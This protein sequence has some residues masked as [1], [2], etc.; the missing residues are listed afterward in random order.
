VKACRRLK[1]LVFLVLSMAWAELLPAQE[2]DAAEE[3][4]NVDMDALF[5]NAEDSEYSEPEIP[6]AR[7][8]ILSLFQP[9][10]GIYVDYSV[11]GSYLPG[12]GKNV[13]KAERA[14]YSPWGSKFHFDDLFAGNHDF[15]AEMKASFALDIRISSSLRFWQSIKFSLPSSFVPTFDEFYCDYNLS[16]RAFIKIGRYDYRW[17]LS[18]NFPYTNLLIR[19]P[20]N[21]KTDPG[22]LYLLKIDVP[23]GIGGFQFI[24]Y[25]REQYFDKTAPKLNQFAF[26]GKFNLATRFVDVDFGTL[27]PPR[28]FYNSEGTDIMPWRSFLSA[29]STVFRATEIYAEVLLAVFKD[30]KEGT[31][32]SAS[33]GFYQDFFNDKL[34]INGEF[35]YNAEFESG[36]YQEANPFQSEKKEFLFMPGTNLALNAVFKPGGVGNPKIALQTFYNTREHSGKITPGMSITP[37]EHFSFYFAV[38]FVFGD[39]DGG[40]YRTTDMPFSFVFMATINGSFRFTHY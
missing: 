31:H 29:K 21:Y 16:N 11:V 20:E 28:I 39:R 10:F 23:V 14:D 30:G 13:P 8:T 32:Y 7:Q 9:G 37:A 2:G 4:D 1:P 12:W 17:G 36:Y 25:T 35:F 40:Y 22:E 34:R 24:S 27:Y 6:A 38:P 3:I 15:G 33:F 19:V 26:G 18:H 5:S